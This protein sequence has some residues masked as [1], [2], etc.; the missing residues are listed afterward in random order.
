M[1]KSRGAPFYSV[2]IRFHIT[3][4]S[5]SKQSIQ[6]RKEWFIDASALKVTWQI[7]EGDGYIYNGSKETEG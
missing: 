5:S 2:E 1:E 3:V 6:K 7:V 4:S